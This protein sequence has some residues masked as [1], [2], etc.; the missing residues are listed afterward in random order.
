MNS[1]VPPSFHRPQLV[2][3]AMKD[4]VEAALERLEKDG[5]IKLIESSQSGH[6]R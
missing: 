2:P 1:N 4:K 3:Y 6:P 5:I